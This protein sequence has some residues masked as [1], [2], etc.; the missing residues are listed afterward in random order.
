MRPFML[1]RLKWGRI[2]LYFFSGKT[3]TAGS[4]S[5]ILATF[6]VSQQAYA[7]NIRVFKRLLQKKLKKARTRNTTSLHRPFY[8]DWRLLTINYSKHPF[9]L[10]PAAL[11][12]WP[13]APACEG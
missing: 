9:S 12:K 13:S 6:T 10:L 4:K 5:F 7:T 1:I 11:S 3:H 8:P 2:L